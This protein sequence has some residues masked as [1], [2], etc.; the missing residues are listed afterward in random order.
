MRE[1][2][3]WEGICSFLGAS[4]TVC[5]WIDSNNFTTDANRAYL[6]IEDTYQR[7][8]FQWLQLLRQ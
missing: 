5:V 6:S 4:V 3:F 1:N 7:G 8:Q 2:T